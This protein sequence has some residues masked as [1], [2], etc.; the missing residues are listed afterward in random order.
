MNIF[1]VLASGKK[2]FEEEYAS[3]LL[4]WFL[5]PKMEH[6]LGFQFISRLINALSK[7]PHEF[8]GLKNKLHFKLRSEHTKE[9]MFDCYLEH[10]SGTA[11]IDIVLGVEDYKIAIENKLYSDSVSEGQLVK[12]YNGLK[13]EFANKKILM[14]FL[15][16]LEEED[17]LLSNKIQEEFEELKDLCSKDGDFKPYIITWQRHENSE[18]P[19]IT[20]I[21][22]GILKDEMDGKIDPIP[23]YTRHTLK[24]LISFIQNNFSGYEFEKEK[25]SSNKA[26]E[27]QYDIYELRKRIDGYVGIQHGIPGLLSIK[28][29][30]LEKRSFQLTKED[31]KDRRSWVDIKIF[32]TIV[33]WMLD[34]KP[35]DINWD[36]RLPFELIEKIAGSYRGQVVIG[37]KGGEKKLKE[38]TFDEIKSRYFEIES[39]ATKAKIT[40]DWIKGDIFIDI[41]QKAKHL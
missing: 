37:I 27:G 34:G 36:L 14:V 20:G 6:G 22:N 33:D 21:I 19:S 17:G 28:K 23:E 11:F 18:Y 26:I 29:E 16:P 35:R 2:K 8:G 7:D 40:S 10:Y 39:V 9:V 5:N 12:E 3:P 38:M 1:K 30:E 4:A 13:K 15:V 24:A 25:I 32:N 31:M 41:I